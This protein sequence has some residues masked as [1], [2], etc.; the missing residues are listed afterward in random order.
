M[1]MNCSS[2]V[3]EV[4]L[5]AYSGGEEHFVLPPKQSNLDLCALW[6]L[7]SLLQLIGSSE[8]QVQ[9]LIHTQSMTL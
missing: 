8:S 3:D 2:I 7:L 1:Y 5:W 9:P 4:M 6:C